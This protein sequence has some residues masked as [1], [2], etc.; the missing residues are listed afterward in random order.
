MNGTT[1]TLVTI[2]LIVASAFFVAIEFA[3]IAAKRHRLEDL[4]ATSPAARAALRNASELSLLLAGSQLGITLCT[5][6]LGAVTKPA[7]HHALTPLLVSTGLPAAVSDVVAFVLALV[8]VTFLH[9]VIGEMAPKSWAIAHPEKSAV[10][11]S[12]PMRGFM[13]VARPLLRVLNHTANVIVARLGTTPVDELAGG[14]DVAGLRQ[15]VEH[16]AQAGTLDAGYRATIEHALDLRERTLT[17][18][19]SPGRGLTSVDAGADFGDVQQEARRSGHRRILVRDG[20]LVTGVVHVRDTLGEAPLSTPVTA[21]AQPVLELEAT[22]PLHEAFAAMREGRRQLAVV[23]QGAE[24][25][26][27]VT[28]SDILPGLL[29]PASEAAVS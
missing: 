18:L 27:V 7:V 21:V 20:D 15:L 9:L 6:A 17:E 11:L 26:G 29:P 16:S 19:V 3:L 13:L 10:M 14:Q 23:R 25:I 28:L 8:I 2:G 12:L 1:V 24:Q 4:A 22:T 5:L